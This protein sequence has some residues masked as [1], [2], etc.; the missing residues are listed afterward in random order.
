MTAATRSANA[1]F[2]GPADLAQP[3][4]QYVNQYTESGA[5]SGEADNAAKLDDLVFGGGLERMVALHAADPEAF[6]RTRREMEDAARALSAMARTPGAMRTLHQAVVQSLI[7]QWMEL[8][9]AHG[10][11]EHLHIA[12]RDGVKKC[13]RLAIYQQRE[14]LLKTPAGALLAGVLK[15]AEDQQVRSQIM[16]ALRQVGSRLSF[17]EALT[18]AYDQFDNALFKY[19]TDAGCTFPTFVMGAMKRWLP[20]VIKRTAAAQDS[21][22]R[23]C[24]WTAKYAQL[25]DA[26]DRRR[27]LDQ[28]PAAAAEAA[29]AAAEAAERSESIA[30]ALE[31]LKPTERRV[32]RLC[33]GLEDGTQHTLGHIGDILGVTK[34]RVAQIKAAGLTHCRKLCE[35]TKE[36]DNHKP[37][38]FK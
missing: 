23:K 27:L 4:T 24:E 34:Q 15:M 21:V 2:H 20:I 29:E 18:I 11:G 25:Q 32:L 35:A 10:C 12:W 38:H 13:D 6:Q 19:R 7:G 30:W 36:P 17:D 26:N 14:A 33:Y 28:N 9:I 31:R 8:R 5:L 22:P 16:G 3:W 37:S 1:Q